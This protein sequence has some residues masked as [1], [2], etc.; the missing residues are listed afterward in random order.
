MTGRK[1][2]FIHDT[3]PRTTHQMKQV[4]VRNGR[5]QFY[6]PQEVKDARQWFEIVLSQHTP[7]EPL[8]GPVSLT[9]IWQWPIKTEKNYHKA[10]LKVT[11]PD[12][13]NLQKLLKDVMTSLNFWHDDAQVAE[14]VVRKQTSKEG[15]L[16]I[17]VQSILDDERIPVGMFEES[18]K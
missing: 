10:T 2:I 12:T 16:M 7:P 9:V 8:D 14:E 5:P 18:C 3:P 13:D 1:L 11:R 4:R 6:E 15:G 17:V